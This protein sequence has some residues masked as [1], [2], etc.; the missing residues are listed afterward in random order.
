VRKALLLAGFG[1][2]E[3]VAVGRKSRS[4]VASPSFITEKRLKEKLSRAVPF[5]DLNLKEDPELIKARKEGCR[6][7]LERKLP[8]EQFY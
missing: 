1:V 5:R 6:K 4:T 8:L 7:L 3:G 2:K